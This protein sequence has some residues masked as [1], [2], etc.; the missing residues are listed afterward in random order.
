MPEFLQYGFMLRAL[1][2]GLMVAAIC[3]VIGL[4]L[5]LRRLSLIADTLAHVSLAGI[6]LGLLLGFSPTVG[7]L[8]V[9]ILGAVGIERLRASGR[10][11]GEA[12]LALFL[13]GG[14]ALAVVL[15]SFARGF[16]ADLFAYLFGS[17]LTVTPL[18]LLLILG[19]GGLVGAAVII[20][21][22]ELFAIAFNEELARVAGI[23]VGAINL[24]LTLLTALT[25]IVA[26]RV[27]GILLVSAMLVIPTVT[28]LQLSRGFKS[29]LS[30]AVAFGLAAVLLGLTAAYYLNLA[31]GGAIVLVALALFAG[32][33]LTK[34]RLAHE[35]A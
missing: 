8:G 3:P 31:A 33:S 24:L 19:L 9:A 18:D 13:S 35:T 11:P 16:N 1:I 17:L 15:L 12:A 5:V 22:K 30:L 2:A 27:V 32:V 25:V 29:A 23:P 14:F 20:F 10:L 26:M 28:A 21:Y 6:A 34:R 4:F 7:A